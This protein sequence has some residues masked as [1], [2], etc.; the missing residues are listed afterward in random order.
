MIRRIRKD[1]NAKLAEN[2]ITS[3]SPLLFKESPAASSAFLLA[4]RSGK[5]TSS[6]NLEKY[7][8][9]AAVVN[10][11][12]DPPSPLLSPSLPSKE[13]PQLFAIAAI[14]SRFLSI[15]I[16]LMRLAKPMADSEEHTTTSQYDRAGNEVAHLSINLDA[17]VEK[18]SDS[19][20]ILAKNRISVQS[21]PAAGAALA[22]SPAINSNQTPASSSPAIIGN[23]LS[24]SSSELDAIHHL[25]TLEG[26]TNTL[27]F[28]IV[29]IEKLYTEH[30]AT[31]ILPCLAF[32]EG[33]RGE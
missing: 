24:S 23:K 3:S 18:V 11:Y 25:W 33:K 13:G 29:S 9:S 30:G 7:E 17:S 14:V 19:I 8:H 6:S 4:K 32:C 10:A 2:L 1:R 15:L 20:R 5:K 16:T 27:F 22:T 21:S 26:L 28:V 12:V 31:V